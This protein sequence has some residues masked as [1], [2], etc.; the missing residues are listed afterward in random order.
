M[1]YSSLSKALPV[2]APFFE[3]KPLDRGVRTQLE[4]DLEMKDDEMS[5]ILL[6][7]VQAITE[8]QPVKLHPM[9]QYLQN[10]LN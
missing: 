10:L 4:A 2:L 5:R 1:D 8:S 9:V 7:H 3:M 6:D